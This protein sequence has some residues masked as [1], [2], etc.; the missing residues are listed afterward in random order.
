M[1]SSPATSHQLSRDRA[2][3]ITAPVGLAGLA[4]STPFERL[5][6]MRF[7]QMRGGEMPC[8][9]ELDLDHLDAERRQDVAVGGIAGCC[10]RDAVADVEHRQEGQVEGGRGAGR[11]G[12]PAGRDLEAVVLAIVRGDRLAQAASGPSAS[13]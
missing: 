9:V 5:L 3:G 6:P 11:H 12:D 4:N 7:R 10:D 8:A 2:A 13:V 1:P